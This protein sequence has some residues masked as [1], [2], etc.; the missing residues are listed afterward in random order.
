MGW[1]R[2]NSTCRVRSGAL[3]PRLAGGMHSM[4]LL[5][6]VELRL[7]PKASRSMVEKMAYLG[8]VS[9][10]SA[11][12]P[13]T[14]DRHPSPIVSLAGRRIRC[15]SGPHPHTH[16]AAL[17]PRIMWPLL[18]SS[19][20]LRRQITTCRCRQPNPT[21]ILERPSPHFTT[22]PFLASAR[23]MKCHGRG[24]ECITAI[25]SMVARSDYCARLHGILG[26]K[27]VQT[28]WPVR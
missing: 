27:S 11:Q 2:M 8:G 22:S 24:L 10:G 3:R 26:N 18:P 23:C 15:E 13:K 20:H 28:P 16:T 17:G 6:T 9:F 21:A 12:T 14:A 4:A 1:F 5:R 7:L 25:L 19:I